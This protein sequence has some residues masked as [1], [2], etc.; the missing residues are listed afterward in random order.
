MLISTAIDEQPLDDFF[1][2]L[3]GATELDS[4]SAFARGVLE[5]ADIYMDSMRERF[6]LY[7]GRGGDWPEHA[8]STQK[9]RGRGAPILVENG[10]LRASLERD[11]A[12][13]LL[14]VERDVIR[15]GST[16][17]KARFHQDGTSRMPERAILDGPTQQ[18]LDAMKHAAAAGLLESAKDAARGR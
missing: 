14:E 11:G 7:S 9:R 13:H 5:A 3:M 12:D 6:D 15:E 1:D 8:L 4:D 10:D 16:D 17:P 2:R 18:T